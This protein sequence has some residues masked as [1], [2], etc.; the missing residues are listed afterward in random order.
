MSKIGYIYRAMRGESLKS[1]VESMTMDEQSQFNDVMNN[2]KSSPFR[3]NRQQRRKLQ[4][5]N[6]KK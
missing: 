4:R 6:D 5:M 3:M 1:I 2:L